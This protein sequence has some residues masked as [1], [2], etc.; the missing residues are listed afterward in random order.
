VSNPCHTDL[1]TAVV[2]GGGAALAVFAVMFLV[3]W[4]TT[5]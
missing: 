4:V 2:F 5:R 3:A 1:C